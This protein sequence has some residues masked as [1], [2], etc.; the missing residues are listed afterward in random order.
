MIEGGRQDIQTKQKT[1]TEKKAGSNA[2]VT[3]IVRHLQIHYAT[4]HLY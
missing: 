4:N 1:R 2:T 3:L